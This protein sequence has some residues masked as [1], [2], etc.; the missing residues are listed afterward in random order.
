MLVLFVWVWQ[1]RKQ[2]QR[3]AALATENC[4]LEIFISP[5]AMQMQR[6]VLVLSVLNSQMYV[7][8]RRIDVGVIDLDLN[9][10][11]SSVHY[12]PALALVG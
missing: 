2:L 9:A 6:T 10:S 4:L 5:A 3:A 7:C 8:V 11:K 12:I 1:V